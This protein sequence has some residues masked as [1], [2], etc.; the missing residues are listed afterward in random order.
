MACDTL[1]DKIFPLL[2]LTP[3]QLTQT[4]ADIDTL[5]EDLGRLGRGETDVNGG[6]E[7]I[8]VDIF[9]ILKDF[10]VV[11][12]DTEDVIETT[13]TYR[14]FATF[15]VIFNTLCMIKTTSYYYCTTEIGLSI[16]CM[17]NSRAV[18]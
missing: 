8:T 6:L 14:V 7:V 18:L 16:L 13:S 11:V 4:R 9:N 1:L 3:E 15:S 2:D 12:E 5:V 10:G 17:Y